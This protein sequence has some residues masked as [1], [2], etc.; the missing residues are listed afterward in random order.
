MTISSRLVQQWSLLIWL[1]GGSLLLAGAAM[2]W[3]FQ[4]YGFSALFA[5][6]LLG[7]GILLWQGQQLLARQR[8][9]PHLLLKALANGD[10]SLGLAT[11]DPLRQTLAEARQRMQQ[12]RLAA[13]QQAQ[14]L[15][16]VLLHTELALLICR[17]DGAVLE[18]SP[19]AVR[20]LGQRLTQLQHL[21]GGTALADFAL[22]ARHSQQCTIDWQ[23]GG[24]PDTLQLAVSVVTIAGEPIRLLSMQSIHTPLN[25]REQ[26]AYN[27]LIRVLTHEVA[28]SVTPLS[29]MAD[30]CVR[31][32]PPQLCFTEP[33]DKADLQLALTALSRRTRHLADF[34]AAFRS[35]ASVPP[36]QCKAAPLGPLVQQVLQLYQAE[37]RARGVTCEVQI[38]DERPVVYDAGQIEQVLINL[39]KNALEAMALPTAGTAAPQLALRVVSLNE[40]QL[41][42]DVQDNGPGITDSTRAMMFVPFFTTKQQ[43]SGIGLALAKQIM[44]NHGGDLLCL[45]TDPAQPGA[46]FRLVFS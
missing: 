18:Q 5:L 26:Q 42:L 46:C 43:G 37:F 25:Q 21:T 10:S 33:E 34:I 22:Q 19:A 16:Q 39:L 27:R 44:V 6:T 9:L 35:V 24:Q 2:L 38:S 29:S 41:A 3:I 28:N 15:S 30:S 40:Q 45:P 12:A 14:F 11:G 36:P 1:T 31:L 23:Q 13:E 17:D 4:R 8:R 20:L 32:L 7:S